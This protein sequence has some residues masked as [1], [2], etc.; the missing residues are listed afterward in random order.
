MSTSTEAK[1]TEGLR[2]RVTKLYIDK[3]GCGRCGGKKGPFEMILDPK[4]NKGIGET[5]WACPLCVE[6]IEDEQKPIKK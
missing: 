3:S 5:L 4:G 1:K 6:E 2:G